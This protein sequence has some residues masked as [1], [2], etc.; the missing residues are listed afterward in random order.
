MNSFEPLTPIS[1]F[2]LYFPLP[3]RISTTIL[4]GV[5]FWGLNVQLLTAVHID[6]QSLIK[7]NHV[8]SQRH[9]FHRSIYNFAII[10]TIYLF[11]SWFVFLFAV[12]TKNLE[13]YGIS[14]KLQLLDFLP[15][16]TLFGFFT[17][18]ILPGHGFHLYG[19]RRFT[20]YVYIKIFNI[21]II[22][23]N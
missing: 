2:D 22:T 18:F 19:R 10:L 9:T 5:Y 6:I 12:N 15:V 14:S 23:N 13:E 4:I 8:N 16:V 17:I 21:K 7:Y 20:G 1:L 3:Y 11:I